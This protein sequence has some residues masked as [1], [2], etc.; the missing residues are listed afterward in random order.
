MKNDPASFPLIDRV[1]LVTGATSGIGRATAAILVQ[2]GA[3]VLLTGRDRSR[4][5]AAA[6]EMNR[7][8]R[9]SAEFL[10]ADLSSLASVRA[11]ADTVRQRHDHLHV[12]VNNAGLVTG[13][14]RRLT[15][16][17]LEETFAVNHLA[18][19]LLTELLRDRL[20]ASALGRVVTVSSEAHRSVRGIDFDDLQGAHRYSPWRAYARSKLANILFTDE[21]A[22]RLAGSGVTANCLHPGVVRTRLWS[23]PDGWLWLL[24]NLIKPFMISSERSARSVASLAASSEVAGLSGRYFNRGTEAVPSRAAQDRQAAARLWEISTELT[25]R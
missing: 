4:G 14:T 18:P 7:D 10:P 13:K 6:G 15:V 16:D 1:C 12:L 22:R 24:G 3:T 21:L 8:T 19:F 20:V 17:G 23:G 5:E 25:A 11:L 2:Q 9:G